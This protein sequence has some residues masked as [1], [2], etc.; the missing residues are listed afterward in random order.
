M[1]AVSNA[2]RRMRGNVA[3]VRCW[4]EVTVS[5]VLRVL[6]LKVNVLAE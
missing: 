3:S 4:G 6:L 1:L 5:H 2:V